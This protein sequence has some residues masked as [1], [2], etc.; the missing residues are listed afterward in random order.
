M[1]RLSSAHLEWMRVQNYSEQ[2]VTGRKSIC[3]ASLSGVKIAALP[4]PL[5]SPN[6]SLNAMRAGSI[7]IAKKADK[8]LTH[9]N[10]RDDSGKLNPYIN[11]R[12]AADFLAALLEINQAI[13]GGIAFSRAFRTRREQEDL[14]ARRHS[15]P[16]PVAVP[17]TSRHE[18][19]FAIDVSGIVVKTPGGGYARDKAGNYIITPLGNIIIP[20][21]AKHGFEWGARFKDPPHFDADPTRY[22]YKSRAEAIAA[23]SAYYANCIEGK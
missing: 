18:S 2:T 15:N 20:I 8:V 16:N 4:D 10:L 7:T 13:P 22:G 6:P 3:A 9:F 11:S 14:Y 12:A 23:A 19:G 17:G 1:A 21:F 5:M